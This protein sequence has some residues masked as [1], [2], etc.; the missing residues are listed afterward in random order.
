MITRENIARDL[1]IGT[2]AQVIDRLK[3]YQD[4]GYDEFSFWIDS[5][6][7]FDR[8]KASLQRFINDVMP[9]LT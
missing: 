5:G 1:T 8:K 9:A 3:R 4:L 6:M 7:S 2:T